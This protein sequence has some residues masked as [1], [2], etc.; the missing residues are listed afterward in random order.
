LSGLRQQK[1]FEDIR[2]T[3]KKLVDKISAE[4]KQAKIDDDAR[5]L[6]SWLDNPLKTGAVSPS[7]KALAKKMAS[8]VDPTLAGPVIELGPGTGPVTDALIARGVAEDRLVLIEFNPEFCVL[9]KKRYPCATIIEGDAYALGRTLKDQLQAPAAALVSSLPLFTRPEKLRLALLREAFALMRPGAPF[10][11]FT[12]AAVS[13]MPKKA[14]GFD[15]H[16]SPR[17][18]LNLPPACVWVYRQNQS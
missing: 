2:R 8:Y 10:I 1:A 3:G 12:Y 6:K 9:L 17:V 13:P 14:G 16:V 15:S 4:V 18:W 7:S 5:F 11:Q